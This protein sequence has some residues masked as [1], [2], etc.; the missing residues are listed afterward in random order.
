MRIRNLTT[1]ERDKDYKKSWDYKYCCPLSFISIALKTK[2]LRT[3][4]HLFHRGVFYY[5]PDDFSVCSGQ[6]AISRHVY[7]RPCGA[8]TCMAERLGNHCQLHTIGI[9]T[10]SPRVAWHITAEGVPDASHAGETA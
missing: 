4:A 10:G 7:I 2:C 6:H 1:P 3:V 9:G 8:G 5:L